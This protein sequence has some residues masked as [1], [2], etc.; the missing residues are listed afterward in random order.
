MIWSFVFLVV[1]FFKN[2]GY[3]N[4]VFVRQFL[5]YAFPFHPLPLPSL[6]FPS[7]FCGA[8]HVEGVVDG[9]V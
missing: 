5:F 3:S 4:C 8:S 7:L 2:I 6:H 9:T 1:F